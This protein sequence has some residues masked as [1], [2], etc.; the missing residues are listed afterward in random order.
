MAMPMVRA[1]APHNP[2]FER[3]GGDVAVR[4]LVDAFYLQM[5][6]RPQAAAI[7]ALHPQDLGPVREALVDYL[8]EWTGG[9]PR[10]TPRRGPPRLG[11]VHAPFA[12]GPE[13][14]DAW[15][16]CMD[17]ALQATVPERALRDE[18]H[19]A[20]ARVAR[21]LARHGRTAAPTSSPENRT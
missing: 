2:H 21:H 17:A 14:A 10:Y 16:D 4:R 7:R 11:R 3:L 19:D 6:Q 9:P 8:T 20:F 1:A 18:L 13:A 5:Q 12:L 15:L